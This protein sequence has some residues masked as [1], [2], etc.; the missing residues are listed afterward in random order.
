MSDDL[1]DRS[2][3]HVTAAVK[4]IALKMPKE[5]YESLKLLEQSVLATGTLLK[6]LASLQ[7][8]VVV[9]SAYHEQTVTLWEKALGRMAS[10]ELEGMESKLEDLDGTCTQTTGKRRGQ[11]ELAGRVSVARHQP[12]LLPP[13]TAPPSTPSAS[14]SQP[15]ATPFY[16]VDILYAPDH[17]HTIRRRS[18]RAGDHAA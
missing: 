12:S 4:E 8:T 3:A 13:S 16:N 5:M 15:P 6:A 14:T 18:M 1:N 17:L 9:G 2:A 11:I 10:R 7:E